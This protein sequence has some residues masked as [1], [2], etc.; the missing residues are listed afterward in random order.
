MSGIGRIART[1]W[2]EHKL[3]R[4]LESLM[5]GAPGDFGAT[6]GDL[7]EAARQRGDVPDRMRRMSRLFGVEGA[8]RRADRYQVLEMSKV[9]NR[10]C[11]R[12]MCGHA[13]YD[14]KREGAVDTGFCP[15][16]AEYRGLSAT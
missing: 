8:F 2:N 6:Q 4:R 11:E 13:L 16:A 12:R 9:C 5:A 3:R 1:F 15:N 10:C 7:L 14:S